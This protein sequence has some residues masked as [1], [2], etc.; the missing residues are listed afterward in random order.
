MSQNDCMS[1]NDWLSEDGQEKLDLHTLW[2]APF[3]EV[4]YLYLGVHPSI[5]QISPVNITRK[6]TWVHLKELTEIDFLLWLLRVEKRTED[7]KEVNKTIW[8]AE[9]VVSMLYSPFVAVQWLRILISS[10][11]QEKKNTSGTEEERK[12]KEK[13]RL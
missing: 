9:N 10:Q 7:T 12:I 8:E 5:L 1:Q 6:T 13:G 2:N 4:R 11:F 3:T